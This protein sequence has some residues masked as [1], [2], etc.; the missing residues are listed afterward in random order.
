[1][2]R[3]LDR[4]LA[5]SWHER[6][7][8]AACA[9]GLAGVHAALAVLGYARTRGMIER[10]TPARARRAA[11]ATDM[12]EA[13]AVARLAAI[14][15][16]NGAVEATCL[17]RSLLLYG[18]LRARSLQPVIRLGVAERHLH[19]FQ[20]HAWV[21]LEGLPLLEEDAGHRAFPE[22]RPPLR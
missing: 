3:R 17:R 15:G 5:L 16:R 21:E 9:A 20:A 22:A 10:V 1:M 19:P 13:Q 8:L 11:S 2:G 6:G 14:A 12:H 4:W 7:I 18:W